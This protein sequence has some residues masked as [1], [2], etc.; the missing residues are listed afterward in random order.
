MI[1]R[2]A[3]RLDFDFNYYLAGASLLAIDQAVMLAT[4]L[5]T[6][7]CF[8]QFVPKVVYGA[9][10]YVLAIANWLTLVTLP[11]VSQA[12]Q[13]SAARGFYGAYA[14][15]VRQRLAAGGVSSGIL[16][17]IAV[18][19]YAFGRTTEASGALVASVLFP[20]T[21]A[22]DDYRSVL[23]G[24]QRFGQ[25]L[26]V[27]AII[28]VG[29]A[30][31]T[32]TALV[33]HQPF[34]V[35]LAANMGSRGLLHILSYVYL[36][37][38]VLTNNRVDEDFSRFGWNLSLVGI[39]GGTAFQLDRIIIGSALGLEVMAG[40]ELAMR[41]TDPVRN[42]GVFM[43]K[44]LFPRAVR[45]SGAAVA[46][47]FFSRLFPLTLALGAMGVAATLVLPPLMHWLFPKYREAVPLAQWQTW[48][49]LVAVALI[50][51]ETYYL[52]Q[53]RFHRTYYWVNIVRP[54]AIIALLPVFIWR[55]GVYG[56]IW[57]T[58][59]A[60]AV[61]GL[62][63]WFRLFLDR[64]LLIR[65]EAATTE[66]TPS[67]PTAAAPCPLCGDGRSTPALTVAARSA[68]GGSYRLATCNSCGLMR[69]EPRVIAATPE[70]RP[71]PSPVDS[72]GDEGSQRHL[73]RR[74]V[75]LAENRPGPIDA[76][77]SSAM[78]ARWSSWRLSWRGGR[79]HPLGFHG[80]GR[81]LLAVGVDASGWAALGWRESELADTADLLADS[82]RYDAIVLAGL[83]ATPDPLAVLRAARDR[84]K[85]NGVFVVHAS[86]LDSALARL[87][88]EHW[89]GLDQPRRRVLFTRETLASALRA[90][91]WRIVATADR[92][93]VDSWVATLT[94]RYSFLRRYRTE[95]AAG[96]AG[97]VRFLDRRRQGDEGYLVAVR[98]DRSVAGWS[99][100]E[101][102]EQLIE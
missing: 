16:L 78:K 33:T 74:L 43:N 48:S 54:L 28:T 52:S 29:A 82:G 94:G 68:V 34:I 75:W 90:S 59:L 18:L 67:L 42:I 8:S 40:Y 12:I 6:T 56:A 60:R 51:L 32:I 20:L 46:R 87:S 2:L 30:A 76:G 73:Q 66:P 35:I 44:L 88:A 55:W 14:K 31:A 93:S 84:L 11:G 89:A 47:R 19:L 9:Y 65:E 63:M 13:R 79:S 23:F 80:E 69:Q 36:Q 95:L 92:S 27:H 102:R 58:L 70:T 50:Y 41:L 7:W 49:S 91:G 71:L 10:G 5:A 38:A 45:V 100:R 72:V 97:V 3:R 85:R 26:T 98:T 96:L 83:E 4:G 22:L 1:R 81:R 64:G 24:M 99:P 62:Y 39:I 15:G 53:E 77:W 25:F 101:V 21:Y 57:T 61:S 37:K 17:I 86:W